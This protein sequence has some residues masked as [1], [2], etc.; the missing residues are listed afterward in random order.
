MRHSLSLVCCA[1]LLALSACRNDAS[2]G[3]KADSKLATFV[4]STTVLL[5]G[6]NVDQITGTPFYKRHKGEIKLPAL[7]EASG[8]IGVDPRRDIADVLIA[9]QLGN[10]V[11]M[12][13]GRFNASALEPRLISLGSERSEYKKQ[14]L[15]GDKNGALYFPQKDIAIGGSVGEMHSLIDAQVSGIPA[16]LAEL[17]RTLPAGDQAWIVSDQ[18]LPLERFPM[19]S[20]IQSALSNLIQFVSGANA[21]VGFDQGAHLHIDLTCR[22]NDDARQVHDAIRGGIGLARLTTRDD[23]LGLLRLFDAIR[24]DQDGKLVHVKADLTSDLADQLLSYMS[25]FSG[26]ANQMLSR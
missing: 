7:D 5:A 19:R 10:P 12:A 14:V 25:G 4:P 9:W 8:R 1:F 16:Q 22:S 2:L 18:S 20:D 17:I 11:V 21:G 15:L 26:R 6:M 3:L 24:V 13:R 23:Q